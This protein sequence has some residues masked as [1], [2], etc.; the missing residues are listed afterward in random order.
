VA[1]TLHH[2][3]PVD[4]QWRVVLLKPSRVRRRWALHHSRLAEQSR[5]ESA[6]RR[7]S[8]S[9]TGSRAHSRQLAQ[10]C[11]DPDAASAA[12]RECGTCRPPSPRASRRGHLAR[13]PPRIGPSIGR[14]ASSQRGPPSETSRRLS[15]VSRISGNARPACPSTSSWTSCRVRRRRRTLRIMRIAQGALTKPARLTPPP[16]HDYAHRPCICRVPHVRGRRRPRHR[17][18]N[19]HVRF[20][21]TS[22]QE[23]AE[24]IGAR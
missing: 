8:R 14:H 2:S 5:R 15:S 1:D 16:H 24:R 11:G 18:G 17:A 23:R 3:I 22:M 10:V 7:F 13:T 9:E 19:V 4:G 6:A 20:R 12:R 21:M